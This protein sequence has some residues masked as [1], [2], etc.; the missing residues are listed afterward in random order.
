MIAVTSTTPF[1]PHEDIT[2]HHVDEVA[3][4]LP[5]NT[6]LPPVPSPLEQPNYMR[7]EEDIPRECHPQYQALVGRRF[8]LPDDPYGIYQVT[9]VE[10]S[11]QY[12][13]MLAYYVK[14]ARRSTKSVYS[15]T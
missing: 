9:K 4:P 2:I 15:K 5:P 1:I 3:S 14:M 13:T 6:H 10:Y 7:P 8:H 11:W 12:L